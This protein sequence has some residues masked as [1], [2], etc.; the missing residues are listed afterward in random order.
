MQKIKK[1][2]LFLP[3]LVFLIILLSLSALWAVKILAQDLTTTTTD[4]STTSQPCGYGECL[5]WGPCS[6]SGIQECKKF[7]KFPEGC[8]EIYPPLVKTRSCTLPTCQYKC[9]EWSSCRP[10][11][12]QECVNTQI[13]DPNC[14]GG[15]PPTSRS[16][17]YTS[18][19]DTNTTI[20]NTTAAPP[21][22]YIYSDWSACDST[23]YQYRRVKSALPSGCYGT[24]VLKQKCDFTSSSSDNITSFSTSTSTT[25]STLNSSTF[26]TSSTC[27]FSCSSWS[28]CR[29]EGY[30]TRQCY[31]PSGSTCV[32]KEEK[33][34]CVSSVSGDSASVLNQCSIF[35]SDWSVCTP[36][37]LQ[38]Q[39]CWPAPTGCP[40]EII[41]KERKCTP[42]LCKFNYSPWG[43]C[44]AGLQFRS[45]ISAF[46]VGCVGG[47]QKLK[48]E[49]SSSDLQI[50]TTPSQTEN[51]T[52][53]IFD[54]AF[55]VDANW[56][57]EKFGTENC[58]SNV[59][60]ELADPDNDGLSN[61]DELR[62]GTNPLIRDTDNDGKIDGEEIAVGTNPLKNSARGE[63]DKIEFEDVKT[64]G[65]VKREI[66]AVENVETVDLEEG[67]KGLLISGKG[68]AKSYVTIFV[69]SELPTILT[70]KT[71]ADGS[72]SYIL[73]EQIEDGNHQVF[74][75]VTDN[76]GKVKSK[77]EPLPF[78]KTA[79]AV[80][81]NRA[82][83]SNLESEIS[84]QDRPGVN[85][86][87]ILFILAASFFALV[88]GLILIGV[89]AKKI[90]SKIRMN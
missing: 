85:L 59:C 52:E 15:T 24:P 46:P 53:E 31:Y 50:Q 87:N 63:E 16:C 83:A 68:P 30:K 27:D 2:F 89:V 29:P 7:K 80:T 77:S 4:N 64:A 45:I 72:W 18:T 32:V 48:Q 58:A 38:F 51:I 65:E 79:Q 1:H 81:V 41:Q 60:G 3:G 67:G 39:K 54:P 43:E 76:E 20:T 75:A 47:E 14:S 5:E 88:V 55:K 12:T 56:K 19:T 10:D 6:T 70:I 61:N 17:T 74:V 37:G 28:V 26:T 8:V 90:I 78:I 35:C 73:K 33:Q 71:N 34:L 57:Q 25:T 49:C 9:L 69:Y 23:G 36:A 66:Y 44:V 82:E 13:S 62:Y 42:V 84:S 21:C 22:E 40:G 86:K 11:G